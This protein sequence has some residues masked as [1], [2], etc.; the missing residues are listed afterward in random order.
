MDDFSAP[1][2]FIGSDEVPA[3]EIS[4]PLA[5]QRVDYHGE[6]VYKGNVEYVFRV[7]GQNGEVLKG[8]V[9]ATICSDKENFCTMADHMFEVRLQ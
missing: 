4:E 6:M 7:K 8:S 5:D 1:L 2:F 3:S 9:M